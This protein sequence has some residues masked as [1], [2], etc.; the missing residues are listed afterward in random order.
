MKK[1]I[2]FWASLIVGIAA[3]IGIYLNIGDIFL[4]FKDAPLILLIPY[5]AIVILIHLLHV[6]RWDIILKS[7]GYNL[8]FNKLQNYRLM[9]YALNYITPTAH[10]GG[11]PLKA[12]ML[13]ED[14]VPYTIGVSSLVIDKSFEITADGILGLFGIIIIGLSFQLPRELWIYLIILS[15]ICILFLLNILSYILKKENLFLRIYKRLN[16]PYRRNWLDNSKLVRMIRIKIIETRDNIRHFFQGHKKEF[17]KAILISASMWLLMFVE[18]KLLLLIIGFNANIYQLFI[19]ISFVG[20]AYFIPIPAALG[21]LEASQ[22]SAFRIL[23]LNPD[24]NLNPNLG[25][26]TS[27]IIRAKDILMTI[28]GLM[29]IFVKGVFNK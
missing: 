28:I 2:V 10:I 17:H 27:L 4:S 8:S 22:L 6:W 29:L 5:I 3:M 9:G 19:I 16:L 12:V 13:K 25:L 7:M 15:V 23:N 14:K 20:L 18:Y 11:E 24:I 21:V 26:A 1:K